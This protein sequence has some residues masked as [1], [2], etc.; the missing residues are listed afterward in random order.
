MEWVTVE[1]CPLCGSKRNLYYGDGRA[2]MLSI[3]DTL[4]GVTLAVIT[5]YYQCVECGLI[6]QSPRLSDAS[7][8]ELYASGDY[9]HMLNGTQELFDTDELNRA[10]YIYPLI[11]GSG[12]HLDI[13]CSRGY[14]L[15]MSRDEGRK[16]LGVEPNAAYVNEGVPTVATLEQIRSQWDTITCIQVFEHVGNPVE[17]AE[18]IVSLMPEGGRLILEVPSEQSPGSPLRLWHLYFY[19]PPVIM[20]LFHA[21]KLVDFQRTPHNL[22]IFEK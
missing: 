15:E 10:K 18:K 14:L 17:Y 19:T 1:N 21:L 8:A 22:F 2:P 4:G 9:R 6:R 13:G 5:S 20:R 7:L 12:S 16:V 11:E 3:P